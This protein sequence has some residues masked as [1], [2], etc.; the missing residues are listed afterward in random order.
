MGIA[1]LF[2]IA[3][4]LL[5]VLMPLGAV[6]IVCSPQL[7]AAAV[8]GGR[9]LGAV[10]AAA[11]LLVVAGWMMTPVRD[12]AQP[13]E[14]ISSV[15][16]ARLTYGV[17]S[18]PPGGAAVVV[19][20]A[21][22]QV[23]IGAA[24]FD[25]SPVAQH[26]DVSQHGDAERFSVGYVIDET[27][28]LGEAPPAPT[29]EAEGIPPEA[30]HRPDRPGAAVTAVQNRPALV[31]IY[32]IAVMGL[33]V[34]LVVIGTRQSTAVRSG[35]W[36]LLL[37]GL[38]ALPL[39]AVGLYSVRDSQIQTA[40]LQSEQLERQALEQAEA[41][42][43]LT[44]PHDQQSSDSPGPVTSELTSYDGFAT[45]GQKIDELPD[46]V[47]HQPEVDKSSASRSFVLSSRRYSTPDE[48]EAELYERL[49]HEIDAYLRETN[50]FESAGLPITP[51]LLRDSEAI[52]ERVVERSTVEVGEFRPS[53]YQMHWRVWLRPQVNNIL[54]AQLGPQLRLERL[55]ILAALVGGLTFLFGLW[56]AAIRLDDATEGK[57]RGRLA[58]AAGSLMAI[59][60]GSAMLL[61]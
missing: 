31:P 56:A 4:L 43:R 46:W 61:A 49:R 41:A 18:P 9:A 21:G 54:M 17:D 19:D 30:S 16:S 12:V 29:F 53:V 33:L 47:H 45:T 52:V 59:V 7:R 15:D 37:I 23:R 32:I 22:E 50:G 24:A 2:L 27:T 13:A 57:Y 48:A 55:G 51:A 25:S 11:I 1:G 44:A 8:N 14:A 3:F 35:A 20:G 38:G 40:S 10:V 60:L 28:P 36:V 5:C 58:V 34:L 39:L 42:R 6:I 26:G